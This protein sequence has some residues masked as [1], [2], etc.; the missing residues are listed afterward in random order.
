VQPA[1]ESFGEIEQDLQSLKRS[2]IEL[3]ASDISASD[4]TAL[5]REISAIRLQ[6]KRL[7]ADHK[8]LGEHLGNRTLGH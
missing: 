7:L 8:A 3:D 4:T 5:A 2:L 6:L 1:S